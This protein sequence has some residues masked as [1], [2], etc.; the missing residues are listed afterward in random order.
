LTNLTIPGS[1]TNIDDYAFQFCTNLTSVFFAG[2]PPV[3][4]YSTTFYPDPML[5]TYYLPGST[6]WNYN[7]WGYTSG[8]RAVLWNPLIQTSGT[9]FGVRSNQFEFDLTGTT[10]IPIVIEAATNLASPVWTPLTNV[11]LTNGLFHFSEPSQTNKSVRYY[12]IS[13]P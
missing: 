13:S 8:P 11:I 12:R 7:F 1:V 3:P 10:N 2:N 4:L 5:T 6:G 9:N